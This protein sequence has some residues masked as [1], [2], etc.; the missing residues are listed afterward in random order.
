MLVLV[1]NMP[2]KKINIK[3]I[4][5]ICLA[6]FV[7]GVIIYYSLPMVY[8]NTF[9]YNL[10]Q[11]KKSKNVSEDENVASLAT[12][13]ENWEENLIKNDEESVAHIQTPE[14]VRAIYIS[15]WVAGTQDFRNSLIKIVDETEL[16]AVIIDI[17]DSTGR[18]SF[19]TNDPEI[20]KIGSSENRIKDIK[21]LTTL[22]HSKYLYYWKNICFPRPIFSKIK[23]RM[24][25]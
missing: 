9:S 3:K 8:S 1:N 7:C 6:I 21:A 16:N 11:D 17:K 19:H 13:Q 5:I 12:H 4:I 15:G 18:I 25:H 20:E 10:N 24:G 22:L 2:E 14:Y 23:T